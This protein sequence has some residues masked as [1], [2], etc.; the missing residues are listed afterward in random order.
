MSVCVI[1]CVYG[2]GIVFVSHGR[3]EK[4]LTHF[5]GCVS[6]P[7]PYLGGEA[8]SAADYSLFSTLRVLEFVFHGMY[9]WHISQ[10]LMHVKLNY[11]YIAPLA[12]L[13]Y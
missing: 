4:W 8:I 5:S 10:L 2:I 12:R 13:P 11:I 3:L 1:V 7:G 6:T 9:K